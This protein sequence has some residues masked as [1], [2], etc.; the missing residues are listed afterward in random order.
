M[1]KAGTNNLACQSSDLARPATHSPT[2]K[3]NLKTSLN[4]HEPRHQMPSSYA[5]AVACWSCKS[6][7]GVQ[8]ALVASLT[9]LASRISSLSNAICLESSWEPSYTTTTMR[10]ASSV[11]R[12]AIYQPA[13][14]G[15][16]I[17]N[18]VADSAKQQLLRQLLRLH[19]Q[20]EMQ[21]G[22][23]GRTLI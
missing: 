18:M 2:S 7:S 15:N 12:H 20:L 3:R 13:C 19:R 23:A 11:S 21:P 4:S 5:V 10:L 16:L 22:S 8:R 14:N 9:T 1:P 17:G 6:L